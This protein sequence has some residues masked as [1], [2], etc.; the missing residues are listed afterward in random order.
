MLG[1]L[2]RKIPAAHG[3]MAAGK[4]DRKAFQGTEIQGKTLGILGAGRIGTEV[5][6]RALAF[7]MRV[8]A[9]D[10]FLTEA[11]A[12]SLGFEAASDPDAIY[13]QAD[14]I[15]VH[16]PVTKETREMLNAAA[17]AVR[18]QLIER[19]MKTTRAQYAQ[20][21]KRVYY[22]SMEFLVGRTFGNAL[23]ALGLRSRVRQALLDFGVGDVV[24]T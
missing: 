8:V 11:R 6:K 20:D 14:F 16:M 24:M 10:P 9:Y 5:G 4:W 1:A 19:W 23:L 2:A 13:Q 17:F 15:T 12:K 18:D 3:T 22:L 21:S 7:G